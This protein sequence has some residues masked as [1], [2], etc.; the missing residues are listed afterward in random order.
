MESKGP[1]VLFLALQWRMLDVGINKRGGSYSKGW[2][3]ATMESKSPIFWKMCRI[4]WPRHG[5]EAEGGLPNGFVLF[6]DFESWWNI[7]KFAQNL[8][9]QVSIIEASESTW[10]LISMCSLGLKGE[11][12]WGNSMFLIHIP[13]ITQWRLKVFFLRPGNSS[14]SQLSH[15]RA[16]SRRIS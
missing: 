11:N 5:V 13:Q 9:H 3:D 2:M 4:K 7:S 6:H 8:V 12:L 15:V 14:M 10:Y 16:L 1:R